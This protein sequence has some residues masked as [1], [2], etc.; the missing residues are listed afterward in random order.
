MWNAGMEIHL[1][2]YVKYG[3]NC[4]DLRITTSFRG[5]THKNISSKP[6]ANLRPWEKNLI[7][8]LNELRLSLGRFALKLQV[9]INITWK[10]LIHIGI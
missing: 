9:I 6:E 4:T 2:P 3:F 8:A 1:G 7:Y 10:H 5:H